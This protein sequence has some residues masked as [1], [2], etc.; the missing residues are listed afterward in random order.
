LLL[1]A[2][3]YVAED[4]SFWLISVVFLVLVYSVDTDKYVSCL[5][6]LS[7]TQALEDSRKWENYTLIIVQL[8]QVIRRYFIGLSNE[9]E[10]N[11]T[12]PN[13][14]NKIITTYVC[15]HYTRFNWEFSSTYRSWCSCLYCSINSCKIFSGIDRYLWRILFPLFYSYCFL[16]AVFFTAIFCFS[17]YILQF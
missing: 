14:P 10:P 15:K 8:Q 17:C 7:S 3:T 5:S 6:L 13:Q 11:Q 1:R 4:F 2:I 12:K 16:S 9:T